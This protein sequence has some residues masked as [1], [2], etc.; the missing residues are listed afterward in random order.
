LPAVSPDA[1]AQQA[2]MLTLDKSIAIGLRNATEVLKN[3]ND[4]SLSGTR[5]LQ[6]YGEFL[7]NLT[8]GGGYN[9]TAGRALLTASGP[10]LVDMRAYNLNLQVATTLNL[11]NGLNDY[12]SLKS[13]L[14]RETASRLTLE[15]AK[16]Q[17]VIDVT[18]SF[19][20]VILDRHIVSIAE[21]NYASSRERERLLTAQTEVG[22]RNQADLYRQQAQ[23]SQDETFL[24][25]SQNKFHDDQVLLLRKLRLDLKQKYDL[26]EPVLDPIPLKSYPAEAELIRQA[27]D[28]RPDLKANFAKTQSAE[29]GVTQAHSGYLPKLDL[30]FGVFSN[31]ATFNELQVNPSSGLGAP[32]LPSS[33]W[34]QLGGQTHYVVG[35][36]LTWNIFDRFL[37]TLDVERARVTEDD[38]RI[39]Y[40][41][42]RLQ[43][44]GE[45]RQS[46]SDY[47]GAVQAL[48]ASRRGVV[49][50]EAAYL[51][52][53]GRYRVGSASFLDLI[54]AQTALVQGRTARVQ[55]QIG[56]ILQERLIDYFLG[57]TPTAPPQSRR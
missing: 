57:I 36:T 7:P 52:V 55:A 21:Q 47:K 8:A 31:G 12:A 42:R 11:F 2:E 24:I 41:D 51:T 5:V 14:E 33:I 25:T 34:D 23:T 9:Y 20:Q 28:Q 53:N 10:T 39:D 46:Y 26:V 19:L 27:I 40:E 4:V 3:E 6:G 30:G 15:R 32:P 22:V 18:Q 54:T 48:E 13:A 43:V 17:V 35:L 50:A 49:A 38:S 45:I 44:I 37:T 56:L 1:N 29:W 16:Q